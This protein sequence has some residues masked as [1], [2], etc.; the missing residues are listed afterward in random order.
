MSNS[1]H[2]DP[3]SFSAPASR[4]SKYEIYEEHTY[5]IYD[6]WNA[7]TIAVFHSKE[8]AQEYLEWLNSKGD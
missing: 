3:E 7:Q 5:E 1:D 6:P 2:L 4:Q 8:H